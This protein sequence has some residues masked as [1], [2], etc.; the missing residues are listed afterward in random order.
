ML[1]IRTLIYG[2]WKDMIQPI[3]EGKGPGQLG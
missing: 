3:A 2:W 1:E